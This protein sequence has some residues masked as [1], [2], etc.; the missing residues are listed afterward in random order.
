MKIR[1]NGRT[2]VV[3]GNYVYI[4]NWRQPPTGYGPMLQNIPCAGID[5][6]KSFIDRARLAGNDWSVPADFS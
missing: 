5:A 2:I 4:Y 1:H 3:N 6:A